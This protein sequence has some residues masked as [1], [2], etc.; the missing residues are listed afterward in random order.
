MVD[1][2]EAMESEY[3]SVALVEASPTKKL[4]VVDPGKYEDTPEY[5]KRLTVGVNIDGKTKRWRPN[6]ETVG[7]LQVLG[8]DTTNWLGKPVDLKVEVR[9]GKKAV[10]GVVGVGQNMV[11]PG[12]NVAADEP[13]LTK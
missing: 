5:G 9:S 4:V 1:S 12:D 13:L 6:K 3:V 8:K 11:A 10:I 2:T 7:N